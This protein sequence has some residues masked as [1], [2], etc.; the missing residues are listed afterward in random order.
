MQAGIVCL[1][2]S[3]VC[4][5]LSNDMRSALALVGVLSALGWQWMSW[6]GKER[7]K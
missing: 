7:L 4:Y 3:M 1:V 6:K 5:F 2:A